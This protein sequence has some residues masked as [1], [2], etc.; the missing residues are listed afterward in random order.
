M[1]YTRLSLF[2][3][4]YGEIAM[5]KIVQNKNGSLTVY[6]PAKYAVRFEQIVRAGTTDLMES[7]MNNEEAHEWACNVI[8]EYR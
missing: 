2:T 5:I 7:E 4:G 6:V 1:V 3:D 8:R